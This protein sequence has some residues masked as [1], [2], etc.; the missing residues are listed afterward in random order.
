MEDLRMY[1][2]VPTSSCELLDEMKTIE[3]IGVEGR[4]KKEEPPLVMC[5][6]LFRIVCLR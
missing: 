2:E 5:M 3:Q 6:S 1:N 4:P